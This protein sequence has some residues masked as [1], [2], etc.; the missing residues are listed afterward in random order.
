M[1]EEI[2]FVTEET[3][4]K[5]INQ[6]IWNQLNKIVSYTNRLM[7]Y[8][9][10]LL[11]YRLLKNGHVRMVDLEKDTGLSNVRLYKIVEAFEKHELERNENNQDTVSQ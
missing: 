5:V 10:N 1:E 8:R 3:D 4:P 7:T 2:D 9:Y 11:L 6:E